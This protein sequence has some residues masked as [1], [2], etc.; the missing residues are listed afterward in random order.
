MSQKKLH[1]ILKNHEPIFTTFGVQH[2]DN[3]GFWR[4]L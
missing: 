4:H 2:L 1:Y 3:P